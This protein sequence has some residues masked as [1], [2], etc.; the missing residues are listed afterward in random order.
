MAIMGDTGKESVYCLEDT[1]D[2]IPSILP[3]K[4]WKNRGE[5]KRSGI[6][7]PNGMRMLIKRGI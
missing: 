2:E 3:W 5:E 4:S 7:L 6:Y 1:G